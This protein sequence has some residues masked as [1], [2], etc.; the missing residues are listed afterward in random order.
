PAQQQPRVEAVGDVVHVLLG[1]ARFL[2]AVVDG[3]KR[4]LPGGERERPLAVL[5]VGEALVLGG[6]DHPPVTDEAGRRAVERRVDPQ[7]D[8][9]ETAVTEGRCLAATRSG[10]RLPPSSSSVARTTSA[11]GTR[12][13]QSW[14]PSGQTDL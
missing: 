5:D 13:S 1:E 11:G 3:G 12:R 9:P 6:G 8:H 7:R 10:A 14:C 2:Q 4:Q